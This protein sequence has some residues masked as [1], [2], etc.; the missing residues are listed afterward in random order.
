MRALSLTHTHPLNLCSLNFIIFISADSRGT[1]LH[2]PGKNGAG[3]V[4]L[5]FNSYPTYLGSLYGI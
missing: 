4:S 1:L 2:P 5:V 3:K